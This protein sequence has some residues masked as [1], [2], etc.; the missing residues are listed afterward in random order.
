MKEWNLVGQE[1]TWRRGCVNRKK[2]GGFIQVEFS[3]EEVEGW[4]GGFWGDQIRKLE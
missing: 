2:M 1:R 3:L 4:G